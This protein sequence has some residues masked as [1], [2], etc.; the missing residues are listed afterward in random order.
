MRF[1][2]ASSLTHLA[3]VRGEGEKERDR[4]EGIEGGRIGGKEE[5]EGEGRGRMGGKEEEG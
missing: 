5:R 3:T 2:L 4:E 1:S